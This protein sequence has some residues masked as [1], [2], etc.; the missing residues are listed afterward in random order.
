MKAA[1]IEGYGGHEV[2][3]VAELD[4]PTPRDGEVLVRVRAASVNPI[5]WKI[6]SGSMK[7]FM[8][9]S[10][11]LVLGA[12]LSGEVAE[13]R[14]GSRFKVGEAVMALLPGDVGAFAEYVSVP[15]HVA[16]LAPKTTTFE[17]AASLPATAQTALQALRDLGGLQ[18]GGSVVVNGASG[19][20][21]VFGVQLAKI[22][23]AKV[24]AV[25]SEANAGF[26]RELGADEVVDYRKADFTTLGVRHDVVFDA[27]SNRTF[28]DC[29]RAL[30]PKGVYVATMPS[31][32]L[33]LRQVFLNAVSSQKAKGVVVK[34]K[35]ED[36]QYLAGLIDEKR[37]RTVI[38]KVFPLAEIAEAQKLSESGRVRGKIV[39]RMG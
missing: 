26:V 4:K 19:G 6:R 29:Q 5:D 11:P 20:V 32:S 12:D 34:S 38:A 8:R 18:P 2:L 30:G 10:F 9:K 24:T 13:V 22:L 14:P 3:R 35:V 39:L 36:L 21:G 15:E 23:G 16:S 25:C 28:A 31:A 33:I 37:L 27:V 17:E 7:L 1:F